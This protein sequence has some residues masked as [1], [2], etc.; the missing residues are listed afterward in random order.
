[1]ADNNLPKPNPSPMSPNPGMNP[2]QPGGTPAPVSMPSTFRPQTPPPGAPTPAPSSPNLRVTTT[3]QPVAPQSTFSA[4]PVAGAPLNAPKPTWTTPQNT[5]QPAVKPQGLPAKPPGFTPQPTPPR[6][7]P[8]GMPPQPGK[9]TTPL[10]SPPPASPIAKAAVPAAGIAAAGAVAQQPKPGTPPPPGG[11]MPSG[12]PPAPGAVKPAGSEPKKSILRFL[13]LLLLLLLLIGGLIGGAWYWFFGRNVDD[14]Q[15]PSTGTQTQKKTISYWGLWEPSTVMSE[16]LAEFEKQ[17]PEYKVQYTQQ[18]HK[19]YR[20]RLQAEVAKGSGPDVFRFHQS[21]VPMLRTELSPLPE[22]IMSKQEFSQ[23]F[24]PVA[25]QQL[26]QN[27][28]IVGLPMMYEGLGLYYN[29][30]IFSIANRV[31]PKNWE[32][33]KQTAQD[34]TIRSGDKITRGGVALGTA[35]NVEHFPEI[36]ALLMLQN[37]ADPA[38]PTSPQ[39]FEALTFYVNFAQDLRV[40]D[41]TLPS[42]TVAFA[43]GDV[44]MMIAPSW[45]AHE[46]KSANPNLQFDIVPVPQ[47][48]DK[49][50][51]TWASFWAEG[52]NAQS[53]EKEGSWLLVKYLTSAEVQKK[54]YNDATK[55]RAFGEIYSRKDLADEIGSKEYVGAY[56]QDAPYAKAWYL[57]GYTHDNGINDR[58]I[59][60][61]E[62]AI[63]SSR[64]QLEDNLVTTQQGITQVLQQYGVLPPPV[65]T[66]ANN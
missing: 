1:M 24:Y 4:K 15:G 14:G 7:T 50:R 41:N 47:L 62:D 6:I 22:K 33:M 21:W 56:I 60:Y 28:Q 44:A 20:E 11:P 55:V 16:V 9:P 46:V 25:E 10:S 53:K 31:P 42:S 66:P 61:Y 64:G 12:A 49:E 45:R 8:T 23:T 26:T 5:P 3:P 35:A 13:P 40:W 34:L 38:E 17:N 19:E 29:K 27:N 39:A 57:N 2:V 65:A 18:S 51:T 59:K 52:V 36:I 32:E 37:G 58:I 54:L 30:D 43:K 63:N 48:P